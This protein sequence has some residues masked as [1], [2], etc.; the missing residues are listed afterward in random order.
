MLIQSITIA[1]QRY[2]SYRKGVDFIQ[3]YIFPGG[4][5]PSVSV[6]ANNV[7]RN[8]DMMITELHDIGQDYAKT[9]QHWHQRFDKALPQVRALGYD[10]TF[11]RLWKFY[12]SYCEGAFLERKISTVHL[13][14][15]KP[16]Y[17][18]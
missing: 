3:R 9:L 12:F 5:L 16:D 17:R 11:I 7:A 8:T 1:D 13:V 14:A 2:D 6:M 4:C 18:G 10:D 15:V